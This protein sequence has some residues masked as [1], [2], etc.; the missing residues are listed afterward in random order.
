MNST[1]GF[2]ITA[3][4]LLTSALL[5]GCGPVYQ[6]NV[7]SDVK[8]MNANVQASGAECKSELAVPALDPIRDKVE[9]WREPPDSPPPFS[10]MANDTFP[11]DAEREA[12]SQWATIRDGCLKRANASMVVPHATGNDA[13]Y[14][15]Q[16]FSVVRD[17]Q[18][19]V[20]YLILALYQQ[21]LTYGE[22]ARKR[23]EITR[24]ALAALNV[25][26]QAYLDHEQQRQLMAQQQLVS[27]FAAWSEYMQAVN[28]RQPQ[29]VYL[30]GTIQVVR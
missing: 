11:T 3:A 9:L 19:N 24:D 2:P 8:A 22:F 30:N 26:R 10:I 23:Y 15:Q 7:K 28:A 12:I 1:S 16:Q 27:T 14:L 17:V 4:I 13:S 29:T 18:A 6:A 25:M 21:K 5:S 20:G